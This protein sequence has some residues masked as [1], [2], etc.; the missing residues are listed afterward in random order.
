M[1]RISFA[2]FL[3]PKSRSIEYR[4]LFHSVC[5]SHRGINYGFTLFISFLSFDRKFSF[6]YFRTGQ[7]LLVRTRS[8]RRNLKEH[9]SKIT[10][11]YLQ[12]L[13][14]FEASLSF[15]AKCMDN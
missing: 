13:H 7:M 8:W 3:D 6:D 11:S 5:K 4:L 9:A 14:Y 15:I 2:R 12:L 1:I 10:L